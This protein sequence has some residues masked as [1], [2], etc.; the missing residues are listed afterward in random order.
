MYVSHILI[1]LKPVERRLAYLHSPRSPICLGNSY[2]F[3]HIKAHTAVPEGI[4]F[5]IC[6]SIQDTIGMLI[7][8]ITIECTSVFTHLQL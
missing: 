5:E 2:K 3:A 7:K 4:K 6:L 1:L 8:Y